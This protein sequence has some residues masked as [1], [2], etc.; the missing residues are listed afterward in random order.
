M[1]PIELDLP[2]PKPE[3]DEWGGKL[4]ANILVLLQAVNDSVADIAVVDGHLFAVHVDGSQTDLGPL[5]V[6]PPGGVNKVAGQQGDVGAQQLVDA[7][8]TPLSAQTVQGLTDPGAVRDAAD[9]RVADGITGKQDKASLK[10]DVGT[11]V[12]ESGAARDAVDGRIVVGSRDYGF[13]GALR[14]GRKLLRY[15]DA[16]ATGL[17]HIVALG[18]S[19]TW[20]VG[21][22]DAGATTAGYYWDYRQYAW[23]VRLRKRLATLR[24]QVAAENWIGLAPDWGYAT[25]SGTAATN[26]TTG[27]FGF[28]GDA[29]GSRGGVSLPDA[30]ARVTIPST[31]SGRFTDLDVF[32]W[33]TGAGVSGGYP[34]TIEIDGSVVST[35]GGTAATDNLMKVTVTGIAN[36]AHEI[37]LSGTGSGPCWVVAVRPRLSTGVTVSRVAVPGAKATDVLGNDSWST[38]QRTRQADAAVLN[39][40]SNLVVVSLTANDIYQQVPL[41]TYQARIQTIIDRAVGGGACVLLMGDPPV[42]NEETAYAIK[43]SQYRAV[44]AALSDSNQ[45]VAF[46]DFASIFGDRSRAFAAGMFPDSGTVHPSNDGHK[47]MA[48]FVETLLPGATI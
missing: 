5:P 3:I 13:R 20:G 43:G 31:K 24:G 40:H 46:A 21:A 22:D 26:Q 9:A 35:G 2:V 16:L 45:H 23:P 10:A 15:S 25:I 18:N 30:S 37:R 38:A 28:M 12:N 19:I 11:A 47:R 7:I 32:Y 29:A 48:E 14:N 44:L 17:A 34:P 4:N 39:G 42:A 33:G 27:A 6:G 36:A 1:P 41:A 8:A